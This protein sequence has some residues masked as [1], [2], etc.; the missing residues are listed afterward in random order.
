MKCGNVVYI[1]VCALCVF[2]NGAL[3]MAAFEPRM[4]TDSTVPGGPGVDG[5]ASSGSQGSLSLV[6]KD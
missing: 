3:K 6:R 4:V 5:M 1:S 2:V